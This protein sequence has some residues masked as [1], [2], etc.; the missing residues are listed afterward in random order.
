[1]GYACTRCGFFCFNVIFW[2]LGWGSLGVGIWLYVAK[3]AYISLTPANFGAMSAA[4]LCI[5]A[6]ATVIVIGFVGCC[7]AWVESKCLLITYF[8]FVLLMFFV[9][10]LTG[11]MGMMYRD[12][13]SQTVRQEL[14]AHINSPYVS[15]TTT[16]PYG[17][18]ITWDK[19]QQE[20]QCCGVDS[21]KD[22][23]KSQRWPKNNFVPDSCCD[24]SHFPD[25]FSKDCGKLE[26]NASHWYQQGCYRAFSDWL[27]EHM[28]IVGVIGLLFAFVEIFGLITSMLLYCGLREREESY[29]RGSACS[30]RYHK[31]T[32]L[33]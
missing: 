29:R 9:G 10:L 18:K 33:M 12:Q 4:G 1:M 17:I 24:L 5:A 27:L 20:F 6:G 3:N 25:G 22:W 30:Y 31:Q 11:V 2:I 13:V 14:L 15:E 21:Y 19:M 7:G 16:D 8:F 28:H 32:S 23:F 26:D